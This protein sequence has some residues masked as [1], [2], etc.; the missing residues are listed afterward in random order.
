MFTLE[1][2]RVHLFCVFVVVVVLPLLQKKFT[3]HLVQ[4]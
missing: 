1:L 4:R 3:F 2:L